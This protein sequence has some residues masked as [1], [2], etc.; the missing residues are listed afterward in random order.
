M[1][2]RALPE[3]WDVQSDYRYHR[4]PDLEMLFVGGEPVISF[5]RSNL[6]EVSVLQDLPRDVIDY[7]ISRLKENE[8]YKVEE[9]K[10]KEQRKIKRVVDCV[11]SE[12]KADESC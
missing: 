10:R 8:Q 3:G 4:N 2:A 5:R 12:M 7:M 11:R 9:L 1:S 6:E